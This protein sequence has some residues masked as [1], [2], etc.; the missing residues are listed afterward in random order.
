MSD[1]GTVGLAGL[2]KRIK[3]YFMKGGLFN[4]EQMD[5]EK[6]RQLLLDC[7]EGLASVREKVEALPRSYSLHF[8]PGEFVSLNSVLAI[9]GA[10]G[11]GK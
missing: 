1:K 8:A 10:T 3:D 4:P 7:R 5:H 11:G 2:E 6:V 9:L